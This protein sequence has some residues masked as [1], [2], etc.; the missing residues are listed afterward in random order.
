MEGLK[1]IAT[2]LT[3]AGPKLKSRLYEGLGINVV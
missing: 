1:D 2:A 3:A